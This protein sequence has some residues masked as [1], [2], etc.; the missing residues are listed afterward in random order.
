MQKSTKKSRGKLLPS[1]RPHPK[2]ESGGMPHLVATEF[3]I[4]SDVDVPKSIDLSVDLTDDALRKGFENRQNRQPSS[5]SKKLKSPV[6]IFAEKSDHSPL[7]AVEIACDGVE[8]VPLTEEESMALHGIPI[9]ELGE[10]HED[11]ATY[12]VDEAAAALKVSTSEVKALIAKGKL[13]GLNMESSNWRIPKAQIRDGTF[14]PGL[15]LI[16]DTFMNNENLW[17]YLVTEQLGD[18]DW[19]KPID[20]H[21][22]NNIKL[23]LEMADHLGT[24][25][26]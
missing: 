9:I 2:T 23:A 21:F 22:Q 4:S 16:K 25:F 24:E 1:S 3:Q 19:I 10:D 12:S 14:A 13:V 20:V 7:E 15:E 17:Q 6:E 18:V 11:Y 8:Y 26:T 5:P